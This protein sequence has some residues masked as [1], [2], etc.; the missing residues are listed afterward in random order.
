M[1]AQGGDTT[2]DARTDAGI[3]ASAPSTAG[4]RSGNRMFRLALP[5]HHARRMRVTT[6]WRLACRSQIDACRR[7]WWR[8][9][10]RLGNRSLAV[11][12]RADSVRAPPTRS[13]R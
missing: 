8:G 3:P 1:L 13:V 9:V 6:R 12:L 10:W 7:F 2:G 5:V 11:W 4:N